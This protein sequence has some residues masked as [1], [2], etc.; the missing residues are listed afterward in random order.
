MK[1]ADACNIIDSTKSRIKNITKAIDEER[2]LWERAKQ[3]HE[4]KLKVFCQNLA[5]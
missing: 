3:D 4:K 2:E 5:Y 1:N